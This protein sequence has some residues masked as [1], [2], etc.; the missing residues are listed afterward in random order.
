MTHGAKRPNGSNIRE[1]ADS[2]SRFVLSPA[3]TEKSIGKQRLSDFGCQPRPNDLFTLSKPIFN[4]ELPQQH[5]IL[6]TVRWI[7]I[8]A[9]AYQQMQELRCCK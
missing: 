3:K 7:S 9:M 6:E 2:K 5:Q 1:I 8:L 4:L